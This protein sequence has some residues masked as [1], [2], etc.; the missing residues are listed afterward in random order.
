MAKTKKEPQKRGYLAKED[1]HRALVETAAAVVEKSGWNALSMISVAEH[2]KV[3][4]QLVY[5]HFDSVDQLMTETMTQIFRDAYE[6]TRESIQRSTGDIVALLEQSERMTYDIPPGRVRALW[7]MITGTY[8]ENPETARMS[9]RLRHLLTNLWGPVANQAFGVDPRE[10][11]VLI[12]M[13]HMAFWGAHQ[14][15]DEKEVDRATATRLFAWLLTQLQ[16]GAVMNP[17]KKKARS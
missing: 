5:E 11:R 9:R 13:L 17:V 8:S 2:A 3:S 14:L 4:R 1:R 16:A 6:S 15:V 10:G 7:Q 12:W